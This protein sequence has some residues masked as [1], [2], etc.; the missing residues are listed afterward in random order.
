VTLRGIED[1]SLEYTGVNKHQGDN[2]GLFD[3]VL[4]YQ[5]YHKVGQDL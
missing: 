1:A 5:D 3:T 2:I 4:S